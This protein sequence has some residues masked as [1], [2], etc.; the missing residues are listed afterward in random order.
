MISCGKD[1]RYGHPGEETLEKLHRIGAQIYRTDQ[2]GTIKLISDGKLV[3]VD[4]EKPF[5]AE[6][7]SSQRKITKETAKKAHKETAKKTSKEHKNNHPSNSG[8]KIG[9]PNGFDI[10]TASASQLQSISGIGPSK[11][12]AILQYREA[13]GPFK[14]FSDVQK[15]KGI[16]PS[17]AQ[18][19]EAAAYIQQ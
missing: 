5:S 17:T 9:N 15:V 13:N 1:N 11:A 7:I 8:S 12:Q 14:N 3:K 10:N 16:G 18:K 4:S 2:L 6:P 19:I